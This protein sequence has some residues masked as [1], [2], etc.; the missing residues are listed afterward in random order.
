M[1]ADLNLWLSLRSHPRML[2]FSMGQQNCW[3][4]FCCPIG[5]YWV[6]MSN[7][8]LWEKFRIKNHWYAGSSRL[9]F[10]VQ[11]F[12]MWVVR[13]GAEWG[14]GGAMGSST[15]PPLPLQQNYK[16]MNE[17][18]VEHLNTSSLRTDLSWYKKKSITMM[19]SHFHWSTVRRKPL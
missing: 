16:I 9:N 3:L 11:T 10:W 2:G 14:K 17:L 13:L 4:D 1:Q 15:I 7:V 19:T 5:L 18:T 8:R 12:K 6:Y